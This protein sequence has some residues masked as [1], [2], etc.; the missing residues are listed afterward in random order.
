MAR[1]EISI[2]DLFY[3]PLKERKVL[4]Q[5]VYISA[6]MKDVMLIGLLGLFDVDQFQG[7][8]GFKEFVWAGM[9]PLVQGVWPILGN[10]PVV[11]PSDVTRCI[12]AGWVCENEKEIR[13]ASESDY[14]SL[15][16]MTPYP[17]LALENFC[18]KIWGAEGL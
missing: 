1:N 11:V 2:G 9:A 13:P 17:R 12:V 3:V 6:K 16:K 5:V 14:A 4:A 15:P 18:D 10:A 8:E 7:N